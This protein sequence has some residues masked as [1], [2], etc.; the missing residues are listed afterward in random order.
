[1]K[2][3]FIRFKNHP[4]LGDL[5]LDFRRDC[6]EKISVCR[7]DNPKKTERTITVPV[8]QK[9]NQYSI[10]VNQDNIHDYVLFVG[11]NGSGKTTVLRELN[12]YN[13]SQYVDYAFDKI[14]VELHARF[15]GKKIWGFPDKFQS[16]FLERDIKYNEGRLDE[17]SGIY[18][19]E[20]EMRD[21]V[22][23][24]MV[25]WLNI[26]ALSPDR[27][28]GFFGNDRLAAAYAAAQGFQVPHSLRAKTYAEMRGKPD[29]MIDYIEGLSSGEQEILLRV[30]HFFK[31][32]PSQCSD[33]VLIDEPETGLH[34][35]WQTKI[36]G[37]YKEMF[38][39]QPE[40]GWV[41]PSETGGIKRLTPPAGMQ[42]LQL[43]VATHAETILQSAIEQ[44]DWLIIRLFRDSNGIV[45][46][47]RIS[48]DDFSSLTFAEARYV[49][50][51]MVSRDYHNELYGFLQNET[52]TSVK[53]L[54]DW[55]VAQPQYD[56]AIHE[57]P[58]QYR[59][60]QY[61]TL[62][63]YIRNKIDH[64]PKGVQAFSE[65]ELRSSIELMRMICRKNKLK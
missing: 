30:L 27:L 43:F 32:P 12:E 23:G 6:S 58:S 2:I 35:K 13:E 4:I 20:M 16:I 18:K 52:N 60:T 57:K 48:G 34:P 10:I 54:D 28:K 36:L 38:Q 45:K 14:N 59:T 22:S 33:S 11:E 40:P 9:G 49:V 41:A 56:A 62:C 46:S 15:K 61:R 55:I 17:R 1:V 3:P 44:G 24:D 7:D 64:P 31:H 29:T 65:D 21:H 19:T 39:S 47:E 51:D 5:E 63:S 37:Y 26:R 53:G 8:P 50:F 25:S 42:K